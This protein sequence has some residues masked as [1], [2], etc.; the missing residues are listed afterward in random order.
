[1]PEPPPPSPD[2]LH[3]NQV[4][5]SVTKY[6]GETLL[7]TE[8]LRTSACCTAKAPAPEVVA[9]LRRVPEEIRAK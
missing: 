1:L 7:K 3:L 8:D 5:E 6:Y 4:R 9:V 2:L